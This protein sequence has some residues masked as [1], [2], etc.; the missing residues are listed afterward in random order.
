MLSSERYA[1]CQI[2]QKI[3]EEL[4]TEELLELV[5]D[6]PLMISMSSHDTIVE[7]VKILA[8]E[9]NGLHELLSR[10]DSLPVV[11]RYYADYKIP[12]KQLLDYDALLGD[13]DKPNYDAIVD[14][15]DRMRKADQDAKVMDILNLCEAVMEIASEENRMSQQEMQAVT[16]L[17]LQKSKEKMKSECVEG[18]SVEEHQE[19][20]ILNQYK[21]KFDISARDKTAETG[22]VRKGTARD[23]S[24]SF[25]LPDGGTVLYKIPR[26]SGAVSQAEISRCLNLFNQYYLT[27]GGKA[28]TLVGNGGTKAY[29]CYNFAWLKKYDPA[30]L[31]KK[32]AL[33]NDIAYRN[34]KYFNHRDYPRGAG[35]VG[36]NGVHAVYCVDSSV[37]Y[38]NEK[39]NVLSAPLVKSKWGENGPLIQHP[40]TLYETNDINSASDLTWFC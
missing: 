3:L 10:E 18:P 33:D 38:R 21:Q 15:K 25:R 5:L 20:S 27:S 34:Y 1:A 7:G 16:S 30:N 13:P 29:N 24:G 4:S 35:W 2:P 37:S 12:E 40:V 28:V 14:H 23:T 8:Q 31:W 26:D 36:S 17:I 39:G 19:D 11:S 22:S 9:F 6:C 32:C